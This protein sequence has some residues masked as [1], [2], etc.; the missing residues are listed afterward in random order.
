M[1]L[2]EFYTLFLNN[3]KKKLKENCQCLIQIFSLIKIDYG[4]LLIII[5]FKKKKNKK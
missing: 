3:K 1:K 2:L 4:E 5:N